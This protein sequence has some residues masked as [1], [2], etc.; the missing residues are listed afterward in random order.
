MYWPIS[1]REKALKCPRDTPKASDSRATRAILWYIFWRV[2]LKD[3]N[4]ERELAS[5]RSAICN[6][7]LQ[8]MSL[9]V[10][11]ALLTSLY[12]AITIG[13][14]PV[15]YFHIAVAFSYWFITL[16]RHDLPYLLKTSFILA[17][18]TLL[19]ITGLWQFGL[20]AP[21]VPFLVIAPVLS[22]LFFNS[23]VAFAVA[24]GQLLLFVLVGLRHIVIQPQPAVDLQA[25]AVEF[26]SWFL[27]LLVLVLTAGGLV[28]ATEMAMHFL[29]DGVLAKERDQRVTTEKK[30]QE[31]IE[32]TNVLSWE[33]DIASMQFTYM[34]PQ[35]EKITGYP[36]ETWYEED[37][38]QNHIHKDDRDWAVNYCVDATTRHNDHV[39]DYRFIKANGDIVWFHDDVKIVYDDDGQAVRLRGVMV[40]ITERKF[41]EQVL[42]LENNILNMVTGNAELAKVLDAINL[43][44]EEIA[45]NTTCAIMLYDE[46]ENQLNFGSAPSI[47][48]SYAADMGGIKVGPTT[49]CSGAAVYHNRQYIVSDTET[50]PVFVDYQ[51]QAKKYN[52][53]ACLSTP[54][55]QSESQ[56]LGTFTMYFSEPREPR[57]DILEL[58]NRIT[59]LAAVTIMSR[60]REAELLKLS[61]AVESSSSSIMI[62]SPTGEIEYI[63]PKF[64]ENTGYSREEVVGENPRML[65]SGNTPNHVYDELWKTITAGKEWRGEFQ[66]RKKDGSLY[67]VRTSISPIKDGANN[68]LY[69]VGVE[70]DVTLEYE[71]TEKL[72]YQASHDALTGLINRPEFERRAERLIK[73]VAK[74]RTEHALCFLDLDQFKVVND[75]CGHAAGDEMLRRLAALLLDQVRQR[76]TLARLGGDEFAVLMEHCGLQQ[77]QRVATAILEVVQDFQFGWEGYT[78]RVGVS[79]GLVSINDN[80]QNLTNLLRQADAACY[81]AKD[82]GRNRIHVYHPDDSD[83]AQRQGEMQWVARI[84]QALEEDRFC[85]FAQKIVELGND[86]KYHYEILLRMIGEEGEIIPPGAFLPAA[87]RYNLMARLD[88]WVIQRAFKLL[89]SAPGILE[90]AGFVSINLSGQSLVDQSMPEFIAR[91]LEEKDID[92]RKICFEITETSAITHL[93]KADEL[94]STL[95]QSGCAF[96]LDDFGSGLSSF[97][98]L[99]KLDVDYLKID[100][101]FVKDI[102]D[103]AIDYAMVKSINE[104]GQIMNMQTIAEFVESDDI[105]NSLGELGVNFGQGYGIEKPMR[106][107]ELFEFSN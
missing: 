95:K 31:L 29:V 104:I 85:L 13:W 45:S 73:T 97:G 38:W 78:F 9:L 80:I 12:R 2:H 89:D 94:I 61:R 90:K 83:I 5:I 70:D 37:F 53:R 105:R 22:V 74:D 7:S 60:K 26:E 98:Y 52:V 100:G 41:A 1:R 86:E 20:I 14:Q 68:I 63:N 57:K 92:G 99:K 81:M 4:T 66:N 19:G 65:K 79:I 101:M 24:S 25:Y 51:V 64:T 72:G 17:S 43:G 102:I 50:D 106:F 88:R 103:D 62:T 30:Y 36:A 42:S 3:I 69:F 10:I 33:V 21:A 16:K 71:L 76:D 91:E 87:E 49:M 58:I 28:K 35:S 18:T 56:V 27:L 55:R 32:E 77:A 34:S 47:D 59:N 46:Q 67:R 6:Y 44:A 40:D 8:F 48:D 15:M 93:G 75:T 23:R 96:A 54:I 107:E 82:L 84:Y 39:F 11:P